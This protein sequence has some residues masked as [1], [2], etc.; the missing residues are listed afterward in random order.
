MERVVYFNTKRGARSIIRDGYTFYFH[1]LLS[2]GNTRY[3][4]S[5]YQ[6]KKC[7]ASIQVNTDDTVSEETKHD[8]E[9]FPNPTASTSA[10]Y[11]NSLK[12][13][14]TESS[15]TPSK[16][17]TSSIVDI[18]ENASKLAES[19]RTKVA[20]I[21]IIHRNRKTMK[22]ASSQEPSSLSEVSTEFFN[23]ITSR[24]EQFLLYDDGPHSK[25]RIVIF[26]TTRSINILKNSKTWQ[27]DG[28]F[29]VVPKYFAQLFSV[30][31]FEGKPSIPL[32]KL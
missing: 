2:N 28:T 12:R 3:R 30:H 17:I 24:N 10:T 31:G 19:G 32:G 4:C 13:K 7:K 21:K 20:D 5:K 6:V 16:I 27:V 26:A 14:A 11:K 9:C 23:I 22:L 8:D 15:D 1:K 18:G 25:E 29:K